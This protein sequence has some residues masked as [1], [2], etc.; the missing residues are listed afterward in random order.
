ML[1]YPDFFP[2]KLGLFTA[3]YYWFEIKCQRGI[4]SDPARGG[5]VLARSR[6]AVTRRKKTE[7]WIAK[8]A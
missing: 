8:L 2:D 5:C 3:R 1:I 4:V 7:F 6:L